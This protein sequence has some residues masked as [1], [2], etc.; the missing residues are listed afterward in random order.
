M[1]LVQRI[2][3]F[4]DVIGEGVENKGGQFELVDCDDHK[5]EKKEEEKDVIIDVLGDI[6]R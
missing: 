4:S 6:G 5:E 1:H 2:P 3:N